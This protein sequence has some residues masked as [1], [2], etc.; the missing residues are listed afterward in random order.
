MHWLAKAALQKAVSALPRA[1]SANY[2]LQR[3]VSRTLPASTE[4]FRRKFRRALLHVE[5][6]GRHGPG[7]PLGDAVFYE[8]GAGWDLAV[9]LSYW[10]LG[11]DRQVLVD[12]RPH[13]RAEL[14]SATLERI[15]RL[16]P[17]LEEE[18]KRP[19]RVPEPGDAP[20]DRLADDFGLEYRAPL[21]ARRTGFEAG[22]VDFVTSTST[23][24]HVPAD[25]L[26]QLLAECRRLLRADGAMSSV[27]DLRDHF[28]YFDESL[29]QYN[30]LR[31]SDRAWRLVNSE[32]G[33]QNRLRC[34][35]YT[36]L[37]EAA[38]FEIVSERRR[39]PRPGKTEPLRGEELA[40]RF[41]D[42]TPEDLA[43]TRL[44]VVARP[45]A[46]LPDAAKEL[47]DLAG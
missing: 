18:A 42:Y 31:Y 24:E 13:L 10:A 46:R 21:D 33:Y 9:P 12:L 6:Y 36:R 15:R 41:R 19:L 23:L 43:V 45:A 28:S 34:P 40:P 17:E 47:G 16:Q 3:H 35:D 22:S 11:V 38:G 20:L 29:S 39:T 5:A 44:A 37:F 26:L 7:R 32:L 4:A 25:D 14:V 1:E 30:F 8:F 2:L 27:I